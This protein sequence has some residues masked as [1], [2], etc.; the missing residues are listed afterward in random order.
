MVSR[1]FV[2]MSLGVSCLSAIN[3]AAQS[4]VD[5]GR[6]YAW[7]ENCGWTNW[8]D[9]GS[10]SGSEG[11]KIGEAFAAGFVWAENTGWINLG[12]GSPANGQSYANIDGNDFGVN[13]DANGNASGLAWGE[14]VGWINFT[15]PM[16]PEEQRPRVD[17]QD[18]RLRGFGW[19]ENVGWLNLNLAT[20]FVG[21]VCD[22]DVNCD[23]ALDGFDVQ[24]QERAVGGDFVDYCQ[25]DPDFNR[26]F[27][28]DGFDV[29]AV[30]VAVGGGPCP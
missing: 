30:E 15:L 25:N 6:K 16:I 21:I 9:A 22:A 2:L 1:C 14:N 19:G 24:T 12:D 27:A 18:R 13:I 23:F 3:A 11:A 8:A 26:D 5:A 17:I 28:L 4:N 29:Q 20:H 7:S 10:P